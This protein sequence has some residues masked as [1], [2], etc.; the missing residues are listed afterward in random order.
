MKALLFITLTKLHQNI[1]FKK[2]K[3][4]YFLQKQKSLQNKCKLLFLFRIFITIY[5]IILIDWE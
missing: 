3:Y 1:Y 4:K 2:N 5:D